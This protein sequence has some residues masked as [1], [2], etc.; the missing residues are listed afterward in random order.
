MAHYAMLRD[1]HF[2]ADEDDIRGAKLYAADGSTLGKVHDVIFDHDSGEIEY[3]VADLGK[4]R[5]VL[6]PTNHV[7]RSIADEDD[8]GT[9]LMPAEAQ[10]LPAFDE[11]MMEE[12]KRWREH[13]REHHRA[14]NEL[15]EKWLGEYKEK[16]SEA[17]VQ[18]RQ[19]TERNITPDETRGDRPSHGGERR[20][21][22]AQ[23]FPRRIAGKFAGADPM[24]VPGAPNADETTLKPART[25]G[26][27]TSAA[28]EGRSERWEQFGNTVR[29]RAGEI[30][31]Q[32]A[33]CCRPDAS[34]VA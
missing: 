13:R 22:A 28:L 14:W 11:K 18:H 9:N 15:E 4:D 8:F 5:K 30:R 16:W 29:A 31:K 2:S 24:L 34:R 10:A 1:Y 32:C 17:P 7:Y 33:F 6:V 12:E 26:E 19:G 21:T 23:L 25:Q 3:L 20:I 27:E